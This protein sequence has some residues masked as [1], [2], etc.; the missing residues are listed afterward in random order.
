MTIGNGSYKLGSV[1]VSIDQHHPGK[2]QV[3][4]ASHYD[5]EPAYLDAEEARELARTLLTA[6]DQLE[7]KPIS[8]FA[9]ALPDEPTFTLLGRD[10]AACHGITGWASARIQLGLN[11]FVDPQIQEALDLSNAFEKY[12]EQRRS[13]KV[14]GS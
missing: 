5:A 13:Q 2:V 11:E 3:I 6:A 9:R 8:C 4:G 14:E 12:A 10:L 7:G 1:Y